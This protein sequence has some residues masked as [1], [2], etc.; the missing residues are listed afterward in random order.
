M[1]AIVMCDHRNHRNKI[2]HL[3]QQWCIPQLKTKYRYLKKR[4]RIKVELRK[5]RLWRKKHHGSLQ[6]NSE[7]RSKDIT[8]SIRFWVTSARE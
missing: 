1:M 3:P 2:N 8:S 4:G 5:N 6:L 7:R